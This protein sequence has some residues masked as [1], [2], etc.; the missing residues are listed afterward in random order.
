M[1]EERVLFREGFC[2]LSEGLLL[3]EKGVLKGEVRAK[4]GVL[5]AEGLVGRETERDGEGEGVQIAGTSFL[6]T[7]CFLEAV[8]VDAIF[9]GNETFCLALSP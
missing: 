8:L 5:K 4:E 7:Y 6:A 3:V 2:G 1:G 9:T